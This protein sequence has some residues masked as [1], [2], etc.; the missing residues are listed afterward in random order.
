MY[1]GPIEFL[2]ERDNKLR[3]ELSRRPAPAPGVR[4]SGLDSGSEDLP[5]I[6]FKRRRLKYKSSLSFIDFDHVS[7]TLPCKRKLD[8]LEALLFRAGLL[9]RKKPPSNFFSGS[10]RCGVPDEELESTEVSV[11]VAFALPPSCAA[12]RFTAQRNQS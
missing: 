7:N 10:C 3:F 11:P 2:K 12:L 8:R 5:V 9:T 4:R 6:G 1:I